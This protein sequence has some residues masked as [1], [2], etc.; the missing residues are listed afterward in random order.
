MKEKPKCES[1]LPWLRSNLG[2]KCLG[3]LTGQD[4]RALAAAVQ[5]METYAF[6]DRVHEVTL[7]NAFCSV[8]CCMQREA[9]EL[10]YHSIAHIMNW[11][12]RARLW[13][14]AR[15]DGPDWKL[16]VRYQ[17]AYEPGGTYKEYQPRV[18]KR[19]EVAV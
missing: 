11:E 13:A 15:I 1:V 8:V 12:D 9:R 7:L 18:Y 2:K 10:A 14:A 16:V 6:S 17:C 19:E 5:I 4:A 3:V